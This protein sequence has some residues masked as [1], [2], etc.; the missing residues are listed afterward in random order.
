MALGVA[1]GLSG[2]IWILFVRLM[3]FEL[4]PGLLFGGTLPPI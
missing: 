1:A 2:A 3:R 4:Y